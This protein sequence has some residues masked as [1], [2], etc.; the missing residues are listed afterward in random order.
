MIEE[1]E[2]GTIT[3]TEKFQV[4]KEQNFI[5]KW[6]LMKCGQT[7]L[8]SGLTLKHLSIASNFLLDS[9]LQQYRLGV[10]LEMSMSDKGHRCLVL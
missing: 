2:F 4:L 5:D 9:E 7:S 8:S 1:S 6:G 3:A 10:S